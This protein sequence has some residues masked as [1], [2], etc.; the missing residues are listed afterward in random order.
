MQNVCVCSAFDVVVVLCNMKPLIQSGVRKLYI[1][2]YLNLKSIIS[3]VWTNEPTH[4]NTVMKPKGLND[5]R[6]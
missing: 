5:T 1:Y 4:G 2:I 6:V 3:T